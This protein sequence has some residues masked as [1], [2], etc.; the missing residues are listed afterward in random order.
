[1]SSKQSLLSE[2][3]GKPH[4]YT[5]IHTYI[6]THT[7]THTHTHTY[8]NKCSWLLTTGPPGNSRV[9]T[10]SFFSSIFS[11]F[12]KKWNFTFYWSVASS[13][14]CDSFR[15]TAKG[16]CYFQWIMEKTKTGTYVKRKKLKVVRDIVS[17]K[18]FVF[19]QVI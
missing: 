13:Q 9:A 3:P 19:A 18:F 6:Q 5:Y 14:C 7:H 12:L 1:M 16:S 17:R 15:G 8:M 10:F 4:I 2:P 11:N